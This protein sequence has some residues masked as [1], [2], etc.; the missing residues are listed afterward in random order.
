[1]AQTRR[2]GSQTVWARRWYIQIHS[3]SSV[4]IS[5][6]CIYTYTC[7][8]VC[9]YILTYCLVQTRHVGSE[10][11]WAR[12]WCIQIR[13]FFWCKYILCVF[14]YTL[15]YTYAHTFF[16]SVNISCVYI[17]TYCMAQTRHVGSEPV[18]ARRWCGYLL[19][20]AAFVQ[21]REWHA[22]CRNQN[23]RVWK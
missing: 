8:Y 1:M 3:F 2:V 20:R 12:R 16:S 22:K 4:N 9:V 14:I 13:F 6:V 19:R 7:I 5:C 17:L 18:W 10:P 21:E 23:S 15:M 11:V